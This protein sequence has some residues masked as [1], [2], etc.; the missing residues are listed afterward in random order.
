MVV[1]S[2]VIGPFFLFSGMGGMTAYNPVQASNLQIWVE[3]NETT[4]ISSGDWVDRMSAGAQSF[5]VKI[6]ENEAPALY[7]FDD[8]M[9]E[10]HGFSKWAE[11]K[12]FNPVQLQIFMPN[13]FSD[14]TWIASD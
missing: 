11:T 4:S 9:F 1:M 14:T 8:V 7:E 13:Q 10:D 2:L 12:F 6:Y 3:V 5:P